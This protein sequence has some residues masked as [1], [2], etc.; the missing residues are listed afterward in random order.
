MDVF[1]FFFFVLVGDMNHTQSNV[2][3]RDLYKRDFGLNGT[4][5]SA[6][7][8][9]SPYNSGWSTGICCEAGLLCCDFDVQF[10]EIQLYMF[11]VCVFSTM[12]KVMSIDCIYQHNLLS[13]IRV[14]CLEVQVASI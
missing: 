4:L 10:K 11:G 9:L 12:A 2:F 5:S 1:F 7:L 3:Q 6:F 8:T 13:A 14:Q